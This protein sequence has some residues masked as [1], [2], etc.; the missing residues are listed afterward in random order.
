MKVIVWVC[1]F[2]FIV[3]GASR[4]CP[5]AE[6]SVV[7]DTIDASDNGD[8]VLVPA[9][10]VTWT[11]GG[12]TTCY[13]S[14][15]AAICIKKGVHLIGGIGGETR[16][17]ISGSFTYGTTVY[18]PDTSATN[19][20]RMFELSGFVFDADGG[21]GGEGTFAIRQEDSDDIIDSIAVHGNTFI[22]DL[23]KTIV[24]NGPV[25]GVVWDNTFTDCNYIFAAFG[26]DRTS[27]A[28]TTREYGSE[29]NI[30]FEDNTINY[31][32]D[33]GGGSG[34]WY[35][36]QGCPGIVVRYNQFDLDNT[37]PE[38]IS[39]IHGLQSMTSSPSSCNASC[40]GYPCYDT[41]CCEQWSTVKGEYY[42]NVYIN[43]QNTAYMWMNHRGSWLIMY[44]NKI[45]GSATPPILMQQYSCDS[46]QKPTTPFYSQHVQ[47]TYVFNNIANGTLIDMTIGLDFC[48]DYVSGSPYT[49]T[50]NVDYYNYDDAFDGTIGIGIGTLGERPATCT[51]GVGY[52]ATDWPTP[53]S[54]PTDMDSIKDFCQEATFYKATG[55][56]IWTEHYTPYTY[57]HPLRG[58]ASG[59]TTINCNISIQ[60]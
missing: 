53:T 9:D 56:N 17:T 50:E 48:S 39:D 22:E 8:T 37:T 29:K 49:I 10:T 4:T 38:E 5:N 32:Y 21:G 7:Q 31:T 34:Q 25:Y 33:A 51:E 54:V 43:V 6:Q 26:Y 18:Y 36:G 57:P 3:S 55:E 28:L 47:N 60:R 12:G 11:S 15:V 20:N 2:C 35:T 27:W 41:A 52:Y 1:L 58:E 40:G 14:T 24:F 59:V 30:F 45:I 44:N 19:N 42:G 16:I 13:N 23:G 46:C